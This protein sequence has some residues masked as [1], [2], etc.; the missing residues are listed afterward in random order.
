MAIILQCLA[1]RAF[2]QP[3]YHFE[4]LTEANGLSDNRVTCFLKDKTGFMWIGTENGLNRFDGHSFLVYLP[5]K[6]GL[7]IS[8]IFINDIEQDSRGRL[9]VA[10]ASGLN[11]IDTE[12]DSTHIFSTFFSTEKKGGIPSDLIWDT[13]VDRQERVWIAP[14]NRDLCFYDISKESF[15]YIPWIKYITGFFPERAK[16]YNSIRRIYYKS[17]DEL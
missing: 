10:T 1:C 13:Y 15:T 14:D 11:M 6:P 9:W 8:D 3:V 17:T 16:K 7:S 4:N 2:A 12:K 5:G